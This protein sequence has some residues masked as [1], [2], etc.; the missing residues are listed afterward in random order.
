[1]KDLTVGKE[2]GLIIKFAI[3]ML[4]GNVFQQLY[5][6]V[7][8]IV[9]GNFIGSEALSAV[10]ASFPIIFLMISLFIGIAS[11]T[12]IIIAQYYG[13]KQYENIKTAADTLYII[14]FAASIIISIVGLAFNEQIFRLIKLPEEIIPSAKIY[15]NIYV[16]GIF[17]VFGF[18]ATSSILRGLGDSK[19]PLY[20]LMLATILNIILD[21]LFVLVFRWGITGV[22]VAT[23]VSEG[24]AF[25]A[26]ILYLNRTHEIIHFS[27][28]KLKFDKD[29]FIRSLK[30]GL[31]TGFQ[32]TFVSLGMVALYRIVNVF[33]TPTIAA[34]SVA[35]RIDAFAIMPAMN[36]SMALTTF[37]GQNIGAKKP[38]R[39]KNGLKVT[40]G[41]TSLMS[42]CFTIIAL[43]FG[44]QLMGLFTPDL[45]IIEI[46][47]NYLVIVSSCYI[48]FSTMFSFNAVFRGAGDT[49]IPMFTTLF[50]LWIIRVPASYFLSLKYGAI[51]IWWGIPLAWLTGTIFSVIYYFMGN[52]KKKVIV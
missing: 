12:T 31:P 24:V 25:V 30:I 22:A 41:I 42:V 29:I 11:G 9:V 1:M 17:T 40:F 4:I 13:A 39:V 28:F 18:N 46:G 8:A 49:L 32:H 26:T 16:A 45:E 6:V 37:V 43:I 51:G 48:L 36:F 21:L 35:G 44:R 47:Y 7:D 10:G 50:S 23:V 19:T 33:G 20:F 52:W 2:A 34:Y 5:N 27:L 14:V 3:P 15:F 38:E